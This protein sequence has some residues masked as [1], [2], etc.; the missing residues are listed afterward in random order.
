MVD[1]AHID[2]GNAIQRVAATN[3]DAQVFLSCEH[4]SERLPAPW[5]WPVEDGWLRGTHWS[6]DIGAAALCHQL[7]DR[8][9]A[10][11]VFAEFSRLLIDPN[12]PLDSP[13]LF[14]DVAEGKPVH[15]NQALSDAERER[16]LA[17][18]HAYH[19]TFDAM[20]S[21]SSAPVVMAIHSFTN[22]YEGTRRTLEVGV[23]YDRDDALA[24]AFADHLSAAG[25]AVGLNEPYSGKKGQAYSPVKHAIRHQRQ[26]VEVEV[27]QDLIVEAPFRQR[28][29]DTIVSFPFGA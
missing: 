22:E 24:E 18:W 23:L 17:Y 25:F 3:P 12:R 11:G 7:A 29:V 2:R 19:D 26:S 28:L 9:G 1:P 4:A 13:T 15:F 8:W 27:R 21:A 5:R 14:R 16:R 10:A 20:L 6:Y